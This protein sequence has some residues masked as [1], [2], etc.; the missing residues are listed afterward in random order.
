MNNRKLVNW[1]G[2]M[3]VL[4]THFRQSEDF[5]IHRLNDITRTLSDKYG[6]GLLSIPGENQGP[7]IR[8]REYSHGDMEI[9][10]YSCNAVTPSGHQINFDVTKDEKPFSKICSPLRE[11]GGMAKEIVCWDIIL[12][13]DPFERV[14]VGELNPQESPPRHPDCDSLYSLY[15]APVGKFNFSS[16]GAHYLVIGRIIRQGETYVNDNNYIPPCR[17]MS[18]HPALV[19]YYKKFDRYIYKLQKSSLRIIEKVYSK[20][21]GSELAVNIRAL[22]ETILRYIA[23]IHFTF[24][25]YNTA[26]SP[27]IMVN[28][29]S[30]MAYHCFINMSCLPGVQK[31]ELLRYFYQWSDI[32]PGSFED[33]LAKTLKIE[34]EHYNIRSIMVCLELFLR[35]MSEL[36]E[37]LSHLEYIGQ[38]K[39]SLVVS[40]LE[41]AQ[42]TEQ[43]KE[44]FVS[45]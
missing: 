26:I 33:L 45:K 16:F 1:Q 31:E 14:A 39:E 11:T 19:E 4:P 37:Q 43:K 13:V 9:N 20:P 2:Q 36:L 10:L 22:S 25:N 40:A 27:V 5:F 29:I 8:I 12:T 44:W 6:Y 28:Y 30:S 38:H 21:N 17:E 3:K 32:T 7:D 18:A 42:N 24:R 15:I 23:S 41:V 35:T 34:Y